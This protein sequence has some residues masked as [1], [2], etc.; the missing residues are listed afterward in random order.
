MTFET[1]LY[2]VSEGLATI[3]LNRADVMN[4]LNT[5][6]RAEIRTAVEQAGKEARALVLT[7]SGRGFCSGQDLADTAGKTVDMEQT[8]HDEYEP[9]LRAIYDCPIPTL[10][11]VNGAAAG[12][13]ANLALAAD[14]VI[15]T[16]SAYFLQAF[17][18]IGLI[19]DAGGTYWM[20]RQMGFA[21]AM[22]A[23]LLADKITARQAD[24][25]GLIW[26]AIPDDQFE[27]HIAARAR[28]L[29]TGPTQAYARIKQ[30]LRAS[31]DNDLD[32][33]LK[34]EARLQGEAGNTRDFVEGV[35]AFLEKRPADYQ[36]R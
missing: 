32:Q 3:T 4:G 5:R 30:A 23:A 10:A 8:L 14:I 27:D 17:A 7:G 11:A 2:D 24:D 21:K 15:A 6:M 16:E 19:P 22:G 18:R 35:M 12:A 28:Q 34:L 31:Y 26:A 33:Q 29:A 13:G 9:M 20:P 1:I 36:G 25:W